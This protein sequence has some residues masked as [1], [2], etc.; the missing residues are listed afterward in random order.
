MKKAS[1][2]VKKVAQICN[3]LVEEHQADIRA[4]AAEARNAELEKLVH[5]V[6]VRT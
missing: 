5:N 6:M 1:F 2:D 3:A 4:A